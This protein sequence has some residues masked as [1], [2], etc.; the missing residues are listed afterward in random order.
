MYVSYF[1]FTHCLSLQ[2]VTY[3]GCA[4]G[5]SWGDWQQGACMWVH[6]FQDSFL[7]SKAWPNGP[8]WRLL[9]G[10]DMAMSSMTKFPVIRC[11]KFLFMPQ[12]HRSTVLGAARLFLLEHYANILRFSCPC[13][14]HVQPNVVD[15]DST[16]WK[17]GHRLKIGRFTH[18]SANWST[19]GP[20]TK[21]ISYIIHKWYLHILYR[22]Q[23]QST[24]HTLS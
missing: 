10:I 22:V 23:S 8:C 12:Q 16:N 4:V 11:L 14:V 15:N 5:K 13:C 7:V 20:W 1:F 3:R 6:C 17:V 19:V 21:C 24:I 2:R 18:F 9:L